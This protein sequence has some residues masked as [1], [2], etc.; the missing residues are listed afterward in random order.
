VTLTGKEKRKFR[1]LGNRLKPEV[2]IG[3]EGVSAGTVHTVLNSFHTKELVKV[4][5]LDNCETEKKIV[6]Q[7]LTESTEAELIQL[8]GNTILLFK[9]LPEGSS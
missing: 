2:W 5:I 7:Q 1:A 9:R 6:A 3:K 4:K 8:I